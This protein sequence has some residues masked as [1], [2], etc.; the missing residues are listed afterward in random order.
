MLIKKLHIL[1]FCIVLNWNGILAAQISG[2]VKD[3]LAQAP[4]PHVNVFIKDIGIGAQTDSLGKFKLDKINPGNYLI[5]FQRVG[6]KPLDKS[7]IVE[8]NKSVYLNVNLLELPLKSSNITIEGNRW[9]SPLQQPFL[10][11]YSVEAKEIQNAPGGFED[12]LKTVQNY[13]GVISRNDY[14]SNFFIRGSSPDQQAIA[15]DG[16]LLQNPYRG[17]ALGFGGLSILNP[18]VIENMDLTL[19]GF[20]AIHGNRMGGLI[21]IHT[22]DGAN[23]WQNKIAVNLL[24]ARYLLEGP[25]TQNIKTV[26]SIRRTYYDWFIKNLTSEKVSYPHFYDLYGKATWAISDRHVFRLIGIYGGEGTKLANIDQFEGQFFSSSTNWL[27]Y[28]MLNGYLSSSFNYQL[29]AA[30]QANHDSLSSLISDNYDYNSYFEIQSKQWSGKL[31]FNWE[32]NDDKIFSAGFQVIRNKQRANINTNFYANNSVTGNS[33]QDYKILAA[34]LENYTLLNPALEFKLGMRW[35]YSELNKQKVLSP[36]LSFRWNIFRSLNISGNWGIF[37]QFPDMLNSFSKNAPIN[38]TLAMKS[39]SAQ[40]SN[41]LAFAIQ[42]NLSKNLSIRAEGYDKKMD[43]LR[44]ELVSKSESIQ[45][46]KITNSGEAK[47]RGLDFI[48]SYINSKIKFRSGYTLSSA[49]FRRAITVEWKPVY[50][51]NRHW[52][53]SNLEYKFFKHLAVQSTFKI[54]SGFPHYEMIGWSKENSN[55]WVLIP[56]DNTIRHRYLRWDMRL[57]YINTNWQVYLEVINVTDARNFDQCLNYYYKDGN[58]Y[59]LETNNL[60]MLPRLPVFG[61]SYKF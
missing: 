50:F 30:Y 53:S 1:L 6:Y 2:T 39:L 36:R 42:C 46:V 10:S 9:V 3:S 38:S 27:T 24:T 52:F 58:N 13:P 31:K 59:M 40:K 51:D 4:L 34:F 8:N 54:G 57:S 11:H 37:Y 61:F 29:I 17:R 48:I 60:Y 16:L 21:D 18:D 22:K 25:V 33:I 32:P 15:L 49:M 41:Y 28:G 35:D 55:E 12:P 44:T 43:N 14:T 23:N 47:I 20:S 5:C 26:F 7:I 56:S 45:Q 19:G